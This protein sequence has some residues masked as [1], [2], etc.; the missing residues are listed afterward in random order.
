MQI[1]C[2]VGEIDM[3]KFKDKTTREYHQRIDNY[4]ERES[5]IH[6]RKTN[7]VCLKCRKAFKLNVHHENHTCPQCK[8]LLCSVGTHVRVPKMN[9]SNSKWQI[10]IKRFLPWL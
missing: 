8:E 10:F 5:Q 9:A 1:V 7:H 2:Y 4:N 6:P 3:P